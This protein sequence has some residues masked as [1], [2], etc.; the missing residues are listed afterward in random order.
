MRKRIFDLFFATVGLIFTFPMFLMI[1]LAIKLDSKGSVF[2]KHKRV[3]QHGVPFL[4]YKFRTMVEN[5]AAI[6]PAV[7]Y[8]GDTRITRVGHLLRRS[9]LDE[10]P[11][12]INIW[13]GEMSFVGPRPETAKYVKHYTSAQQQ[14][15][16]AKPG[17]TGPAQIEWR[18]EASRIRGVQ[19]VDAFYTQ[20]I[21]P[22]KLAL[23]LKYVQTPTSVWRDLRYILSTLK[24]IMT[25]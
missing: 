21:M 20:Y 13:T 9:K 19:N 8:H 23:D 15:L 7:T 2:F 22:H 5:A 18:D 11:Q 25:K 12:L 16:T 17:I 10:L 1:A 3:G 6:G 24:A 4:M 14:V